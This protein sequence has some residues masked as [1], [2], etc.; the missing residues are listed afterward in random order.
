MILARYFLSYQSVKIII[1]FSR[2][3]ASQNIEVVGE[4]KEL[5]DNIFNSMVILISTSD[6]FNDAKVTHK[7]TKFPSKYSSWLI[8]FPFGGEILSL[9]L[10]Y[11]IRKNETTFS[12]TQESNDSEIGGMVKNKNCDKINKIFNPAKRSF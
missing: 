3:S 12:V 8:Y 5:L 4:V 1:F 2:C 6:A 10:L 11:H 9:N 7:S